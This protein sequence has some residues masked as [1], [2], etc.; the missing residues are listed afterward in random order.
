[1]RSNKVIVPMSESTTAESTNTVDADDTGTMMP[2]EEKEAKDLRAFQHIV[3]S[4]GDKDG[5]ALKVSQ[6]AGVNEPA[7][8]THEIL[9]NLLTQVKK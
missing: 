8:L 5:K 9:L 3:K 7:G 6:R 4:I 1:M 2:E